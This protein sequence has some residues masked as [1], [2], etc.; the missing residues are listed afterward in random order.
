VQTELA[1]VIDRITV[2]LEDLEAGRYPGRAVVDE[3]LTDGYAM[4]L[5]LDGE[6]ARLERR[7]SDL[8]IELFEDRGT[9]H[10]VELSSLAGMLTHRR[11]ELDELRG[12]L[13][14]LKSLGREEKV[15]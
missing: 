8:A 10:A 13:A 14:S 5:S 9:Q 2:L 1:S 3:T 15:A 4:A 6:C 11:R 12:L 7:I